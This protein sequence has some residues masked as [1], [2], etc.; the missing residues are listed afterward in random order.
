[1]LL[2]ICGYIEVFYKGFV[3]KWFGFI[4]ICNKFFFFNNI[5][6]KSLLYINYCYIIKYNL[7]NI[8]NMDNM[9]DL[10]IFFYCFSSYFIGRIKEDWEEWEDDEVLIFMIVVFMD[11]F[12]VD[13][14]I[15]LFLF[16]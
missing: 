3:V 12:L 9:N 5:F 6:D 10:W 1:M 16:G 15:D 13:I 4:L 7:I 14:N 11:G 2:F 8:F